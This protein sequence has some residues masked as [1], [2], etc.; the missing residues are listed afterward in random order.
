M[1]DD[2]L[3]VSREQNRNYGITGM[4]LYRGGHFTQIVEGKKEDIL[5]LRANIERDP[6][7]KEVTTIYQERNSQV[8]AGWCMA[9]KRLNHDQQAQIDAFMPIDWGVKH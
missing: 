3:S 9:F 8:F 5:R 7:R 4:L 1:L 2:I 6:R